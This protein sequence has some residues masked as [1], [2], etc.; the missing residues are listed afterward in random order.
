MAMSKKKGTTP[1]KKHHFVPV[2]YLKRFTDHNGQLHCFDRQSGIFTK[3]LPK[4]IMAVNKFYRQDWAPAGTDPNILEITLGQWLEPG[5]KNSLDR[6]I[7]SPTLLTEEDTCILVLY[8][9]FQRIRVPRQVEMAKELIKDMIMRLGPQD[10]MSEVRE[11]KFSLNMNNSVRFEYVKMAMGEFYPW[12][13]T[14]EWEVIEAENDAAFITS[15]SPL[16]L[17]NPEIPPPAEAGIGL[18]GTMVFFP[19]S[20]RY[21]LL[22]RHSG[23]RDRADFSNLLPLPD[24]LNSDTM[25][26]ITHGAIWSA[27]VVNNFNWK[28]LRLSERFIVAERLE[29]LQACIEIDDLKGRIVERA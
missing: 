21:V 17:Y 20:S 4:A 18:A 14:M 5:A 28:M 29:T 3:T 22:M 12:F 15:D 25:I 16:S 2:T 10:I 7:Q 19:L 1:P 24:P 26:S 13:E 6:L 9:E 11:G 23:V 27:D 8:L